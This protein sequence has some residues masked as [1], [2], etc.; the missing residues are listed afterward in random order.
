MA[1]DLN[2]Q[3]ITLIAASTAMIA[4][5]AGPFVNTRIARFEFRANVLS[6]IARNG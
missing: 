5:I 3:W 1:M 4:S 6:V 2:P